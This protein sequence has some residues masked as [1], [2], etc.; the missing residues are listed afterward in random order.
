MHNRIHDLLCTAVL[1]GAER[2]LAVRQSG[3]I[4]AGYKDATELV[5]DADR[6]SD[7]AM[8]EIFERECPA[9][10]ASLSFRLEESGHTGPSGARRIG[11]DPLDGTSHFAAGGNLYSVQAHYVDDGVATIGV[12]FQ[13]EV[14]LPLAETD[15]PTGRLVSGIHGAGAFVRRTELVGGRFLLGEARRVRRRTASR[16]RAIIGCVPYSTKMS[17]GE[18]EIARRVHESGVIGATTGTGGAGG[19]VMWVLF[20]G[21]DLYANF[22][23]G[24]DLDLVPPQVIAEEA[25]CTVWGP[26]RRPPRWHVRKQ[27]FIVALDDDTAERVL[28]AA[29]F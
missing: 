1:A 21:H 18:R 8:R 16:T 10:D 19:N 11:A 24:E 27:P 12:V 7:A 25:G 26:D 5:T 23:A 29:G 14:F 6:Q 9:I 22:G 20:G 2:V 3:A 4:G 15:R 13:P 17:A 28:R